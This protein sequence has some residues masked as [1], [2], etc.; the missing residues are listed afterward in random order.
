MGTLRFVSLVNTSWIGRKISVPPISDLILSTCSAAVF[1]DASLYSALPSAHSRARAQSIHQSITTTN[2]GVFAGSHDAFPTCF[3]NNLCTRVRIESQTHKNSVSMGFSDSDILWTLFPPILQPSPPRFVRKDTT[4][5][6]M[7]ATTPPQVGK[8]TCE[9]LSVVAAEGHHLEHAAF[10]Q[11][12]QTQ[13]KGAL[14]SLH[15]PPCTRGP[16]TTFLKC[17]RKF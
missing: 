2:N 5:A 12:A 17:A 7:Y 8:R 14:R 10:G 4:S 3:R 9:Q 6:N 16:T 1:R 11:G 13:L 15:L